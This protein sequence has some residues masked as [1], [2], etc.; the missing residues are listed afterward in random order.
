MKKIWLLILVIAFVVGALV[1]R[2]CAPRGTDSDAAS[3]E[4]AEATVWTCAMHP[5]IRLPAPGPCPICGME[6][7]PVAQDSEEDAL[8]PREIKLSPTA[9]KLA[10]VRVATVERRFVETEFPMMGKITYDETRVRDV[11]L[12][13]EGVIERLFVNYEGVPM[14]KGDHLAEIYSPDVLAVSKELLVAR[15]WA[16]QSGDRSLLEGACRKL[17]LLGVSEREIAEV[18]ETGRA[19]N[20]FTLYSPIDGILKKRGGYEGH[21]LKVG[22]HL[23]QIADLSTVWALLDAYESNIEHIQYGQPVEFTVEAFPGRTF[24]GFVVFISPELMEMTRTIKV[25]LNVPNPE[26]ELRPGMFVRATVKIAFTRT[27][28][29]VAPDLAGKWICPMHPEIVEDEPGIC[30]DCG[31]SLV[32]PE[33]VGF[34]PLANVDR[35][36]PLVIPASAPLITGKR[37]LVYVKAPARPGVYEGREI[38]LGPRAGDF[39]IVDEGLDEGEQVVVNG[40]FKIDSAIQLQAK[41]SMMNPEEDGSTPAHEGSGSKHEGSHSKEAGSHSKE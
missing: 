21:W 41:P 30:E 11:A 17:T 36:A 19:L 18:V 7:T 8:G 14:N 37:A 26:L 5:Q 10:E 34:P 40:N 3:S 15:D 4:T 24:T 9:E 35:Q 39:Y 33:L 16:E 1:G 2:S 32:T 28:K 13:T 31:M 38:T 12:L 29:V 27:G 22:D 20:T 25:R 23:G 6:V